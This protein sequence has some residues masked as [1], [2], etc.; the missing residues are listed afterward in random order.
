M[1]AKA[2][3]AR[4]QLAEQLQE[5]A[6][7]GLQ[8][9]GWFQRCAFYGGTAL[10]ILHGLPRYSE[11]LDFTLL[12]PDPGF[13]FTEGIYGL[14]A[15]LVS[16][17]IECQ[18]E[19]KNKN[20][21]TAIES[22]FIKA[23]TVKLF[24][25]F[26]P[27]QPSIPLH[28]QQLTQVKLEV[29]TDPPQI[30]S[31]ELALVGNPVPFS[32]TTLPLPIMMA[33]KV[34]AALCRAWKQRVKGRDWYDLIWYVGK[35]IPLNLLALEA[36]LKQTGHLDQAAHLSEDYTKEML[37]QTCFALDWKSAVADVSPFLLDPR[38]I[39]VMTPAIAKQAIERLA[40]E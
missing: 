38:Q 10:R 25:R 23:N 31:P 7:L 32:I 29:D 24:L 8:R 18:V 6:L 34:H 36:R 9:H 33:G 4:L 3:H 40:F 28:P 13:N 12:A 19:Q 22:A 30:F 21:N 20:I 39:E 11:N 37:L 14:Q 1:S 15:E 16:L 26:S 2:A 35:K 5:A 27:L 17:G